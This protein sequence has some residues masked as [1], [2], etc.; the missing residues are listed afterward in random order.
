MQVKSEIRGAVISG[1]SGS[2]VSA[3]VVSVQDVVLDMAAVDY[4]L[5]LM[6]LADIEEV[7][8]R[9]LEKRMIEKYEKIQQ[10]ES[11]DIPAHEE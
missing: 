5:F 8:R 1:V 3:F 9:E 10:R 7:L 6:I 4:K 11:C 2:G